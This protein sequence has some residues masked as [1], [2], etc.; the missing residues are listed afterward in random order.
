MEDGLKGNSKIFIRDYKLPD[1]G[2]ENIKKMI[3]VVPSGFWLIL[4]GGVMLLALFI[5]WG[6]NGKITRTM[7]ASGIYH[8]GAAICGEVI[9]FVPIEKGKSLENGM[10]VTLYPVG[11]DQQEYGHMTGTITYVDPYVTSEQGMMGYLGDASVVNVFLGQGPVMAVVVDLDK[12]TSTQNGFFWSNK[13]G[14]TVKLNDGTW[15]TMSVEL[16][17]LTPLDYA[18]PDFNEDN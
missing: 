18:F 16:E 10:R 3:K 12:D 13:R 6:L 9:S 14:G 15:M 7:P 4:A 11:K 17:S 2:T 5:F 1:D 8:P